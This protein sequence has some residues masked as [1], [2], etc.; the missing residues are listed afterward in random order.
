MSGFT[1]QYHRKTIAEL[2]EKHFTKREPVDGENMQGI[3]L[4]EHL[5]LLFNYSVPNTCSRVFYFE[6]GKMY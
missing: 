2:F 6:C 4:D 5:V 3:Q 1:G